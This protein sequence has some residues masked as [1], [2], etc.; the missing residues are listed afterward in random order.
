M[1]FKEEAYKK[2]VEDVSNIIKQAGYKPDEINFIPCSGLKGDNL[3][4]KSSNLSWYKGPT[5]LEQFDNFKLP[6]NRNRC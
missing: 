6:E 2:T 3:K 1:D 4:E 5:V